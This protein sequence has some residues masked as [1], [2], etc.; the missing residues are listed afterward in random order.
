[1]DKKLYSSTSKIGGDGT[2]PIY[3]QAQKNQINLDEPDFDWW[4]KHDYWG[5][6][7][8]KLLLINLD[9]NK[10]DFSFD[11]TKLPHDKRELYNEIWP[12]IGSKLFPSTY[13]PVR[14]PSF[15]IVKPAK[16]I[17][18]M[19]EKDLPLPEKLEDAFNRYLERQNSN[20]LA[21]EESSIEDDYASPKYNTYGKHNGFARNYDVHPKTL[22]SF[23]E[24]IYAMATSTQAIKYDPNEEDRGYA[25]RIDTAAKDLGYDINERNAVDYLKDAHRFIEVKKTENPEKYNKYRRT[26]KKT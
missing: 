4:L 22:A 18:T 17:S 7:E 2:R 16:V 5:E 14:G 26:D 25:N 3:N 11:A 1:M 12:I 24:I 8:A 20:Q 21:E 15:S 10:N 13:C 19:K 6:H 23:M 9:P